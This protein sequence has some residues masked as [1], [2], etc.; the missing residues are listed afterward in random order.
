MQYDIGRQ[1]AIISFFDA[2]VT[3][4]IKQSKKELGLNYLREFTGLIFKIET[5]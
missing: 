4:L 1:I 2:N 5:T 3:T